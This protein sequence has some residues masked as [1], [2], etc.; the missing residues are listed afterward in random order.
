MKCGKCGNIIKNDKSKFCSK[1]GAKLTNEQPVD[2]TEEKRKQ[3][4]LSL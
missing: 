3:T 1:C 4:S 2:L